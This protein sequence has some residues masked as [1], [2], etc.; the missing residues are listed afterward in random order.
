MI[1]TLLASG[2][3]DWS[4]G[5]WASF[6]ALISPL[7]AGFGVFVLK[8]LASLKDLKTQTAA[9]QTTA[10]DAKVAAAVADTK[11]DTAQ[12][13]VIRNV[14]RTIAL[15]LATSPTAQA[16]ATLPHAP[17]LASP[18]FHPTGSAAATS[19]IHYEAKFPNPTPPI[20][21]PEKP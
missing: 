21:P 19:G 5:D 17:V 14:D 8:V 13:G 20:K 2:F 16:S 15:A 11:A 1:P 7:A 6:L 18:E 10:T 3:K 12:G 4:P 9:A